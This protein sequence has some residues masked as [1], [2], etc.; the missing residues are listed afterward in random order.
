MKCFRAPPAPTLRGAVSATSPQSSPAPTA[1]RRRN[2]IAWEESPDAQPH[3]TKARVTHDIADTRYFDERPRGLAKAQFSNRSEGAIN[4]EGEWSPRLRVVDY[5]FPTQGLRPS[6]KK[7]IV[8]ARPRNPILQDDPSFEPRPPRARNVQDWRPSSNTEVT[9]LKRSG[10]TA[11]LWA[12]PHRSHY[13]NSSVFTPPE[14][15]KPMSLDPMCWRYPY[16]RPFD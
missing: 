11:G 6:R 8:S 7:M 12:Q 10:F 4:K 1:P 2:P 9:N 16:A 5:P 3:F 13:S 14:A 15:P